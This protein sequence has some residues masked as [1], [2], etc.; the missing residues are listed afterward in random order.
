VIEV[1]FKTLEAIGSGT[2]P[3]EIGASIILDSIAANGV[4]LTTMKFVA[5]RFILAE[6]N[7]HRMFSRNAASSRAIPTAKMLARVLTD[8][9]LPC[10]WGQ[11]QPGMQASEVLSQEN[12]YSARTLWLEAMRDAVAS[13]KRLADLGV[14]KQI[15]NR[16]IE[17]FIWCEQIVTATD[18]VNFFWQRCDKAAQPE[19]REL[20]RSACVAYFNSQPT[21]IAH[22]WW[23]LPY[24]YRE[25]INALR[26]REGDGRFS[27]FTDGLCQV[28]VARCAR[29][30]YLTHE[31][32][33]DVDKDLELF[34]K[35]RKSGHWS[36]FEHVASPAHDADWRF[37]NFHGWVQYRKMFSGEN[38][39][40]ECARAEDYWNNA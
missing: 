26:E 3:T 24:V 6:I 27:E 32:V 7:T 25:D 12:T 14:H 15:A 2:V 40:H 19:F 18:W 13:A 34:S 17:P 16:L 36:P 1:P 31:G 10:E 22:G 9:A 28:S 30:S 5:P 29:V 38:R 39:S 33:R 8:P 23:H 20:A 4:R 35:L 37:G 11:N 21:P